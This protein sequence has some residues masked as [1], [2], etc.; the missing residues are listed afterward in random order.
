MPRKRVIEDC[1]ALDAN[2]L[3]RAG[4]FRASQGTPCSVE[5]QGPVGTEIFHADFVVTGGH[6]P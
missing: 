1:L 4:A 3:T 2:S 6:K 5:W